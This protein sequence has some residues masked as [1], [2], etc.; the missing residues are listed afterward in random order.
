MLVRPTLYIMGWSGSAFEVSAGQTSF[1]HHSSNKNVAMAFV[2]NQQV[3][4]ICSSGH[5]QNNLVHSGVDLNFLSSL[6]LWT[7]LPY[8]YSGYIVY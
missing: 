3:F 2:L 8:Q 1:A 5:R 7:D 6:V 4:R